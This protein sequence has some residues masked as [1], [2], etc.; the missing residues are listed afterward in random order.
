MFAVGL[1]LV[2]GVKGLKLGGARYVK[3]LLRLTL[4]PSGL[5]TVMVF[6]P[7]ACP[8]SVALTVVLLVAFEV[9]AAAPPTETPVVGTIDVMVGAGPWKVKP[10]ASEP[11]LLSTLI[12]VTS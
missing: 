2:D 7:A 8:G 12:T 6:W 3:P 10:L 4:W 9:T 11:R 5:V 1:L